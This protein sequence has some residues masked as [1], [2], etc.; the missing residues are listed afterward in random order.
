MIRKWHQEHPKLELANSLSSVVEYNMQTSMEWTVGS[1]ICNGN[2]TNDTNKN[3]EQEKSWMSLKMHACLCWERD[4]LCSRFILRAAVTSVEHQ[5]LCE[6][7]VALVFPLNVAHLQA[8]HASYC[9]KQFVHG[10]GRT[11]GPIMLSET[12][13]AAAVN[14]EFLGKLLYSDSLSIFLPMIRNHQWAY[15]DPFPVKTGS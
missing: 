10:G 1:A 7:T 14:L 15:D 2:Q 12:I 3:K 13:A 11:W 4:C 8:R 9:E 6:N 5:K